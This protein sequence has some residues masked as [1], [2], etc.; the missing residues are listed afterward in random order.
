MDGV[1]SERGNSKPTF[2]GILAQ[3]SVL[4]KVLPWVFQKTGK[5]LRFGISDDWVSQV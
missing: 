2:T 4:G 1:E 5:N 3:F